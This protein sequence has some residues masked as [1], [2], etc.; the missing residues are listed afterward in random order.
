MSERKKLTKKIKI[1]VTPSKGEPT[2]KETVLPFSAEA[3]SVK[4]VSATSRITLEDA[5][6]GIR[7]FIEFTSRTGRLKVFIDDTAVAELSCAYA[8]IRTDV[9]DFADGKEHE[10]LI[11]AEP[12]QNGENELYI[13]EMTSFTVGDSFFDITDRGDCGISVSSAI[14]ENAVDIIVTAHIAFPNNYDV[15]RCTLF[16]PDGTETVKTCKPTS[17]VCV[18]S[19]EKTFFWNG[20]HEAPLYTV[21]A[22]LLRDAHLLDSA[23]IRFGVRKTG[24]NDGFLTLN[25]V[26][27]PINGVVLRDFSAF[28]DDRALFEELDANCIK[29]P[30][31]SNID[32]FLSH[33]DKNGIAVWVDMTEPNKSDASRTHAVIEMLAHHP[34]FMFASVSSND[35]ETLRIFCDTVKKSADGVFTA[36]DASFPSEET[37]TDALPDVL[38]VTVPSDTPL[39]GFFELGE[40]FSDFIGNRK[41]RHTAVFAQPPEGF[42]ERH[43]EDAAR[44]DCSQEYFS[45]WHEKFWQSFCAKKGVFGCFAGYLT[46]KDAPAGRTGLTSSDRYDKKDA[47]WFYK[48]QFSADRF[49]KLCSAEITSTDKKYT[50]IKYY[51]NARNVSISVNGKKQTRSREEISNSV[52]V[53]R[54]VKLKRKNNI[55]SLTSDDCADSA[56]IYRSKSKLKKI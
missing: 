55:I 53:F 4:K 37:L 19:P 29:I 46:D 15:L 6:P 8:P 12:H 1:T 22:E 47:F 39:E 5:E 54:H 2:E 51:A 10:L 48:A 33:C 21:R 32:A 35:E 27:L 52:Y 49:I 50:D 11:E 17:P 13:S 25:N 38:A 16:A 7:A 40:R 44:A 42:Y 28:D 23:E 24:F 30:V 31:F 36:G 3:G 41:L 20:Q 18:F 43:S 26:K 45:T 56:V 14:S 9:T 34:S